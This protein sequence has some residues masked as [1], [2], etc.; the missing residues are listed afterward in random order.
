MRSG[1]NLIVN[2]GFLTKRTFYINAKKINY[3]D[4]RQ[5]LV[6][7]LFRLSSLNIH[8]SGYGKSKHSI[9][10]ILPIT[11]NSQISNAMK[12]LLPSYIINKISI[13]P[14]PS[15]IRR[16]AFMPFLAIILLPVI[17]RYAIRYFTVWNDIIYF[18][19]LFA[20]IPFVWLLIVNI[21]CCFTSGIG[22]QD[23]YFTLKYCTSF[24][25]HTILVHRDK[26]RITSY[27]VCYTKLL[28]ICFCQIA[29]GWRRF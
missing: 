3:A 28:R 17:S 23:N 10:V 21:V 25:F 29:R 15:Q 16:F 18:A 11:T 5:S 13:N 20:I 2:G 22:E 27:N 14:T 26:I 19:A 12:M 4:I 1:K 24:Q 7:I 8:C 6:T 9:A